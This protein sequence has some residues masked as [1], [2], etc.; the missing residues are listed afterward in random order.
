MGLKCQVKFVLRTSTPS[1]K[2]NFY[3]LKSLKISEVM[4][5]GKLYFA[6][7]EKNCKQV[8]YGYIEL[9]EVLEFCKNCFF[10]NFLHLFISNCRMRFKRLCIERALIPSIIMLNNFLNAIFNLSAIWMFSFQNWAKC[11]EFREKPTS[12]TMS[13]LNMYLWK[14]TLVSMR[15]LMQV[16]LNAMLG[17]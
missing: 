12:F 7:L 15:R 8:S 11:Q 2:Y 13:P 6:N 3:R 17:K 16:L 10:S 5:L 9:S 14:W 1:K 4:H